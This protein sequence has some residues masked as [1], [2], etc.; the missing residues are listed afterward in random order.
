[1]FYANKKIIQTAFILFYFIFIHTSKITS[2]K[3][4]SAKDYFTLSELQE[5][6]NSLNYICRQKIFDLTF[7]INILDPLRKFSQFQCHYSG[8]E[9]IYENKN[10]FDTIFSKSFFKDLV[11]NQN[12]I[13][14]YK[15]KKKF[16]YNYFRCFNILD[17][18]R[19]IFDLTTFKYAKN[20]FFI[21]LDFSIANTY[22]IAGSRL[23]RDLINIDKY[24]FLNFLNSPICQAFEQIESPSVYFED[25]CYFYFNSIQ[26]EQF[27]LPNH[28]FFK[29]ITLVS[30]LQDIELISTQD[31][32]TYF[33]KNGLV[34]VIS[35]SFYM[36]E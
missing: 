27:V 28:K 4:C 1:M 11:T 12:E 35:H 7:E 36:D 21:P 15:M 30:K 32:S 29:R 19:S 22:L 17:K 23:D 31:L 9:F 3:M 14:H 16:F 34:N 25:H 20:E 33:T 5:K 26:N 6:I 10:L 13:I 24:K 2:E 18:F 8:H